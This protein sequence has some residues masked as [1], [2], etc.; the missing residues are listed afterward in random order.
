MNTNDDEPTRKWIKNLP[1]CEYYTSV[2]DRYSLLKSLS[3]ELALPMEEISFVS[4][5]IKDLK[6]MSSVG[7]SVC[8]AD[9]PKEVTSRATFTSSKNSG[10]GVVEE[11]CSIILAALATE[12]AEGE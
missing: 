11:F 5:D 7:L 1:F 3:N 9:A 10:Y 12:S 4:S 6:C 8:S 2:S